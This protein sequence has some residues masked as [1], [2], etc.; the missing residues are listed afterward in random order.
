MV[1]NFSVKFEVIVFLLVFRE[2]ENLKEKEMVLQKS[3][4]D[5]TASSPFSLSVLKWQPIVV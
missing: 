4:T 1:K 5:S 2:K 3:Q